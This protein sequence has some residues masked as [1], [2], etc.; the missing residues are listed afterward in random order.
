M[1]VLECLKNLKN[2]PGRFE[3]LQNYPNPFNP[4]TEIIY[5]L[6]A[7][8]FVRMNVYNVQGQLIKKL[9]EGRHARGMWQVRWDGQNEQGAQMPSGVYYYQLLAGDFVE[10]RKMLLMR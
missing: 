2:Q 7:E 1:A 5:Q 6:P 8:A 4:E 3:L 9:V 10:T